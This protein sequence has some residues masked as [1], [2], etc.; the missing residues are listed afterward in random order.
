MNQHLVVV[1][2]R[3]DIR[4]PPHS[5]YAFE[6]TYQRDL[7]WT[8][9]PG[10]LYSISRHYR[11]HQPCKPSEPRASLFL[12]ICLCHL[13]LGVCLVPLPCA[14]SKPEIQMKLRSFIAF[15]HIQGFMKTI[16]EIR[17]LSLP[18]KRDFNLDDY[19]CNK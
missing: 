17:T 9:I 2:L 1:R 11:T 16:F 12:C 3:E 18:E 13:Q 4:H 15:F 7:P 19:G 5:I 10:P 6:S 14:F 8:C